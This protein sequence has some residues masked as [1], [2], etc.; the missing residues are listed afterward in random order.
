[1]PLPLTRLS[2]P[3]TVCVNFLFRI[4]S[5]EKL[6]PGKKVK[7]RSSLGRIESSSNGV[8]S[9]IGK[10]KNFLGEEKHFLQILIQ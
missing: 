4:G 3:A 7:Y 2:L 1:M 6:L 10:P 9:V 5:K 8:G